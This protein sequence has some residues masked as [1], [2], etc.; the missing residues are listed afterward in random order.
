MTLARSLTDFRNTN[1]KEIET[2]L[3][4]Q[5]RQIAEFQKKAFFAAIGSGFPTIVEVSCQSRTFTFIRPRFRKA[6]IRSF[7]DKGYYQ[8]S[9]QEFTAVFPFTGV[10]DVEYLADDVKI[11]IEA[12]FM[13]D[14]DIFKKIRDM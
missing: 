11:S 12:F 7:R 1:V 10:H 14:A 6:L 5:A 8:V 9:D 4:A 2:F 13:V 3:T